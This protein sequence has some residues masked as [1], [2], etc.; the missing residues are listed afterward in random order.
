MALG[1]ASL[2]SNAYAAEDFFVLRAPLLPFS[3]LGGLVSGGVSPEAVR[4]R[5]SLLLSRREVHEALYLASPSLHASLPVYEATPDSEHGQKI[6]RALLRYVSRMCARPTPFE[7]LG[8]VSLGRMATQARLTLAPLHRCE[9]HLRADYDALETLA[10]RIAASADVQPHLRLRPA[11]GLH[12]V[13]GALRYGRKELTEGGRAYSLAEVERDEVLERVLEAARPGATRAELCAAMLDAEPAEA[14]AFIEDLI[15]A[16]LLQPALGPPLTGADPLDALAESVRALPGAEAWAQR[17]ER[18]RAVRQALNLAPLGVAVEA[19][20]ALTSALEAGEQRFVHA[21]LIRPGEL[22]LPASVANEA[23]RG[24]DALLRLGFGQPEPELAAFRAAFAERYGTREVRLVEVLDEDLGIGLGILPPS[25]GMPAVLE[26]LPQRPPS[27]APAARMLPA[28]VAEAVRAALAAGNEE[29][30]LD[31][32]ALPS[33]GAACA[34]PDA[35][36]LRASL[37]ATDAGAVERGEYRLLLHGGALGPSGARAFGRF[38]RASAELDAAVR[39]H[40]RREEAL[41]PDAVFMEV[42]H[43]PAP[44]GADVASRPVLRAHELAYLGES[45]APQAQQLSCAELT[46]SL[47][48]GR[49][50]LRSERLGREVRPRLTCAHDFVRFGVPL[51]T[52][53]GLLQSEGHAAHLAFD[54]G[55]LA[56]HPRL[57]R[58]RVGRVV[59]ARARWRV[60]GDALLRLKRGAVVEVRRELNVPRWV[61]VDESE[62]E[63]TL[64]LDNPLHA[65]LLCRSAQAA[66]ELVLHELF[67]GPSEL[68]C[69]SEE[70]PFI[71][72]LI[73]PYAR[74]GAAPS[75]SRVAPP[76]HRPRRT[77][78]RKGKHGWLY[79]RW[80]GGVASADR[81]L[82]EHLAPLVDRARRKGWM[83]RWFFVRYADPWPHLRVRLHGD[84]NALLPEL[85]RTFA[86]AQSQGALWRAALDT[87][88]P[89]TERYGG[90]TGLPLAERLFELSSDSA[91]R[92]LSAEGGLDP[93]ARWLTAL[94]RVDLLFDALH[95]PLT[96]RLQLA[97]ASRANLGRELGATPEHARLLSTRYRALRPQLDH[98]FAHPSSEDTAFRAALQPWAKALHPAT[99]QLAADFAHMDVNRLLQNNPRPQELALHDFLSR[100]Y[101]SALARSSP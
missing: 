59:L 67:P 89:E 94:R 83:D 55:E 80:Y 84:V 4:S 8:G 1:R 45:G 39:A 9:R 47:R 76:A 63:L 37:A 13:A 64:D 26:G 85:E 51:Y 36:A 22:S 81:V 56:D 30:A 49:L 15:E 82:L 92:A 27:V 91:L 14:Q 90:A 25:L 79:A 73:L 75:A 78:E 33:N 17:L 40:L 88:E 53:L 42:V 70:G 97:R 50:V 34:L 77:G 52:L 5:L 16:Q 99:P 46:L 29:C 87:Y 58:V 100:R 68:L 95:L 6:E 18:A 60:A 19:Y 44:A 98:R 23:L 66:S 43:A 35:F 61:C 71:H 31:A 32:D 101:A 2:L 54:W 41:S 65:A 74:T 7:L 93:D 48:D 20:A 28:A 86:Q 3:A 21:D 57:P 12:T 72:E 10:G 11:S 69:R 24:V 38:C 96:V 62:G